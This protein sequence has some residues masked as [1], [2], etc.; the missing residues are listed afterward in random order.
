MNITYPS[1]RAVYQRNSSNVGTIMFGGNYKTPIDK[2]E[3]RLEP[4]VGGNLTDWL[5]IE[6]F[7]S[8]GVYF[9]S[10][11]ATG[12]WYKLQVRGLFQGTVV[13]ATQLEK[14]GVGEVFLIGGQSNA[15]GL[16][17]VGQVGATDDR[18]NCIS[19][20]YSF[21]SESPPF[22]IFSKLNA[23]S[24]I[25]PT[26]NG[27]WCWGQLG[28]KLVQRLNVPVLFINTAWSGLNIAEW[29]KSADGGQS[30]NPI[31]F[32]VSDPGFP[33][34]SMS[35][36]L[37]HY[38]NLL[39]IRA[40]LWIQG[41]ADNYLENSTEKYAE[42]L[43][44]VIAKTRERSGKNI[45]W[46]ISRTSRD[47]FKGVYPP[48]IAGQNK[49]IA[50]TYNTFAG[51]LTDVINDRLDGVHF[52]AQGLTKLAQAW[53]EALT[54]GFFQQSTP[55]LAAPILPVYS[56]CA[57]GNYQQPMRL[58]MPDGYPN[59][60]WSNNSSSN[61]IEVG[62]GYHQGYAKDGTGNTFYTVPLTYEENLIPSQPQISANGPV[63]FCGGGSVQ[64]TT[65]YSMNTTWNTGAKNQSIAVQTDGF[66]NV[67]Y[68][69]FYGCS[70]VSA[71][72][73]VTVLPSPNPI[74]TASGPTN[75]CSDE[76]L[77]LTSNYDIGNLWTTGETSKTIEITES[78]S[79]A[80]K[81]KNEFGCEATST[82]IN[83]V[84]RP[85]AQKP[86]IKLNGPAEFCA[87]AVTE[88]EGTSVHPTVFWN[89]NETS[90]KIKANQT[91]NYFLN[92]KNE[93]DCIATSEPLFIQVNSLPE[94]P[95]ITT[96]DPIIACDNR[97]IRLTASEGVGYK[98]SNDSTSQGINVKQSGNYKVKTISEK[99]CI[100][101][102]SD[103][104]P[105]NFYETPKQ[106]TVQQ[107]GKYTLQVSLANQLPDIKYNWTKD[108]NALQKDTDII[109]VI[110]SGGYQVKASTIYN[111]GINETLTC[112]SDTSS[113]FEFIIS[114]ED[115]GFSIHPNPITD[116]QL[117]IETLT[118]VDN[119]KITLYDIQGQV[120]KVFSVDVFNE[121]KTFNLEG[122]PSGL[123]VVVIKNNRF[124]AT[125]KIIIE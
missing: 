79:I 16:F 8:N 92:A 102:E 110:E 39:G 58:Q 67:S 18:V 60:R 66:Y 63:D 83:T 82:T 22:P 57:T 75:F 117:T 119:A 26:G 17:G 3:V 112:E 98:W 29:R 107:I 35:S 31:S 65:N 51:P 99:G 84:V 53:N 97:T 52:S 20:F 93:F 105:I 123:Y 111:V 113:K 114:A 50:E 55:Q 78:K 71:P 106:P 70:S 77:F 109:K 87:D 23:E 100:S 76:K 95:I 24:L 88:I 69:N 48:I 125:K 21:N 9:G 101:P 64:L 37:Q 118:E 14:V 46:V 72:I 13:A 91:G 94:K 47:Q 61:F 104:F 38:V 42:D 6:A 59:Y 49:V 4:I 28:D 85:A 115:A 41:E 62:Q 40:F 12:G 11:N 44:Y 74:V 120:V 45:S 108:N 32:F 10:I 86:T 73:K 121:M 90:L 19:N 30:V 116:K 7:I 54:D 15:Q 27:A 33:F 89:N 68:T 96:Q 34:N 43:K 81:I 36:S 2:I 25:A 56:E 80:I 5:P 122:I 1:N 124:K 103:V